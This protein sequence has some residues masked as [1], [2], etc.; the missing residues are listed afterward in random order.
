MFEN[1]CDESEWDKS[2]IS[3][4][5]EEGTSAEHTARKSDFQLSALEPT[6][7]N[8]SDSNKLMALEALEFSSKLMIELLDRELR[9]KQEQARILDS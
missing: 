5:D 4:S 2:P 1:P 3:R 6:G 8:E 9:N 7:D